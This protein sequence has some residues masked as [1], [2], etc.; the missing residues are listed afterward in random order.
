[1]N[2]IDFLEFKA[3]EKVTLEMKPGFL[4]GD[5]VMMKGRIIGHPYQHGYYTPAGGW[6]SVLLNKK[7]LPCFFIPF[8]RKRER[9]TFRIEIKEIINISRGW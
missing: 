3:G 1:M 8:R 6:S 7:G 5:P 9:K 4:G 2:E